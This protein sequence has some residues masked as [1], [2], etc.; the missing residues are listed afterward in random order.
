MGMLGRLEKIRERGSKNATSPSEFFENLKEEATP[1]ATRIIREKTGLT[2]RD[3]NLDDV[4]LP[5]HLSMHHC[6]TMW[7]WER[8]WRIKQLSRGQ[9]IYKPVEE[10]TRCQFDDEAEVPLW[11]TGSKSKLVVAWPTFH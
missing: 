7:C 1:F 5:L 9:N 3:N 8:G 2:T 11:T 4:V 10:Y 6:Y